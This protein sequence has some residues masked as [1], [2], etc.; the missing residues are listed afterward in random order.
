M[1]SSTPATVRATTRF[2]YHLWSDGTTYQGAHSVLVH[3]SM[4]SYA[5]W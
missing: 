3:V 2:R 1:P 5:S 4:S